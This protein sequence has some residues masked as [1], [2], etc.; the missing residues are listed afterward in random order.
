[1]W[2]ALPILVIVASI[3]SV[4]GN[5]TAL[6]LDAVDRRASGRGSAILGAFQFGLGA[7]VA[8]LV[9]IGDG[10]DARPLAVVLVVMTVL[11]LVA[12]ILGTR[13]VAQSASLTGA[14]VISADDGGRD[15]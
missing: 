12:A 6:S 5:A 3:G 14:R 10:A 11:G 15:R 1:M 9:G 2:L 4:M 7:V 13:Q 8:P